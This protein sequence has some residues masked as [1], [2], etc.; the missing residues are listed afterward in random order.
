MDIGW[1][2]LGN[3][4]LPMARNAL[5]AGHCLTI[6]NRTRARAEELEPAGAKIVDSPA[7]AAAGDVV[8]TMLSDDRAVEEVAFGPGN[9]LTSLPA[10]GIHV[11]AS[12]ISVELAK[13]LAQAHSEHR[14][15]YISSPVFGRPEA[16]ANKTLLAVLAGPRDAVE[17][18]RPLFDSIANAMHFVGEE[19]LVANVVKLSGNFL[20]ASVIESLGEAFALVRKYG[21]NP[22][23]FL[24]LITGSLFNAP[25]YK[26]YGGLI[27]EGRYEPVGFRMMLGLKDARL[28]LAA[29]D[30]AAVPMPVASLIR[31]RL[32][33]GVARGMEDADWSS[34]A[35]LAAESAGLS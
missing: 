25:V 24:E 33:S 8:V 17:R 27:A 23:G 10:G 30:S 22:T 29:A 15:T 13:R 12:T 31:D 3:M 34:V 26:V 1:I 19:P 5:K 9:L 14:Q 4:G 20:I 11:C 21:V 28:V 2:G 35:R 6:Y 18:L 7:E 16:A 32:L